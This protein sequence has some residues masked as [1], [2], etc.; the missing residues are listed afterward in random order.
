[1]PATRPDGR[2]TLAPD[3]REQALNIARLQITK[4]LE[5]TASDGAVKVEIESTEAAEAAVQSLIETFK[6]PSPANGQV[7]RDHFA[8]FQTAVSNYANGLDAHNEE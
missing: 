4:Y 7:M 1:M 8:P 5:R 3:A 6:D 2:D